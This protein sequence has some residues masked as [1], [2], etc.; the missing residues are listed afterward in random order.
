MKSEMKYVFVIPFKKELVEKTR[1]FKVAVRAAEAGE[2]DRISASV[3]PKALHC[4]ELVGESLAGVEIKKEWRKLP[5]VFRLE[6]AGPL[7]DIIPSL[8]GLSGSMARFYF[9]ATRENITSARVL[10]SLMVKT[11]LL[12]GEETSEWEALEDLLAYDSCGKV[13]HS[14]VEPFLRV[15]TGYKSLH[16]GYDE[17][18]LDREGVFFHCDESGNVA[19]SREA[20]RKKDCIGSLDDLPGLDLDGRALAARVE[21]RLPLAKFEGCAVCRAWRVCAVRKSEKDR[22]CPR[23]KFMTALLEAAEEVNRNA[24]DNI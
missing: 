5:L 23:K 20:L 19:L 22:P 16:D 21:R 17:L 1:G 13:A 2:I 4:I 15:Y 11:G 6:K 18:Y 7:L 3:S 9:P 24:D 8:P 12:I 10:S 14:A